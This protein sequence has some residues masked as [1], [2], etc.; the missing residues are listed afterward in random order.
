MFIVGALLKL[1]QKFFVE[2]HNVFYLFNIL[3][4][5]KRVREGCIGTKDSK[6]VHSLN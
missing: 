5:Y 6:L 4:E 2:P 3:K 1:V